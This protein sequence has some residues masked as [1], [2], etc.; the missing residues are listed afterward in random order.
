MPS[1]G[2]GKEKGPPETKAK[3]QRAK[4]WK[5]VKLLRIFL[6]PRD[7]RK[8]KVRITSAVPDDVLGDCTQRKDHYLIRLNKT[9]VENSP[10]AVYL[11]LAHEWAHTLSWSDSAFD[12]GDSWGIA[13]AKCWR[14]I[15]GEINAGDLS[16]VI[17]MD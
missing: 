13:Y 6:T 1:K 2:R 9:T 5:V 3:E 4:L 7:R 12:H 8:V 17:G 11:V 10:D 15:T 14:V 16:D